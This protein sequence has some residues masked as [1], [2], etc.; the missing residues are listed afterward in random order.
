MNVLGGPT[1]L[2]TFLKSYKISETKRF[3]PY[4][5][6]V[7]AEKMQ[8]T[9]LLPY[10]AFYSELRSC[11]L[12]E[13]E[14]NGYV[15]LSKKGMATEQAVLK[16]NISKRQPTG[17]ENYQYLQQIWKQEQMG[18]LEGNILRRYS[19]EVVVCAL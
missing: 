17:V 14:Y 8:N 2:D 4:K 5:W 11:I 19:K 3:F 7:Y 6:F 16:L 9:Y 12:F 18:S 13:A 1:S 10:D 15:T